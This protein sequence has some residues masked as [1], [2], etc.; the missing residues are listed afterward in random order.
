MHSET[1]VSS[2]S[3]K[4][5]I[6]INIVDTLLKVKIEKAHQRRVAKP[7]FESFTFTCS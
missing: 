4:E 1:Q 7:F 2:L 6:Q 3:P 5:F